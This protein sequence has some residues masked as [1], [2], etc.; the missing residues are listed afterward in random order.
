MKGDA[1]HEGRLGSRREFLQ[2][3]G[4][5]LAATGLTAAL[6]P[7]VY[8]GENNTIKVALVGCGGRGSGAAANALATSGP[9]KLWAVADVFENRIEAS[10]KYLSQQFNKQVD[11]SADRR[12]IGLDAY[13]KAIDSLD[14][15]DVVILATPPAFR[16]IHFEY[17]VDKGRNVF[18]EKSFAVDAPGVH[19]VMRA[20][21]QAAQKG[22]KVAAGL[23]WRHD[24]PRQE[25]IHRLH[26]GAIGEIHTLRTYRMHAA[27]GFTPK[28][29]GTSELAHQII[30][31][32][33]F[34]WL[35]GSFFVDWLIHNIDVCCW[36]KKAWPVA[37]QGQGGRQVRTEPDQMFDHYAVEYQFADGG[38]LF[39]Q[40][41]HMNGCWGTFS[42]YAH[43]SK[44]SAVIMEDLGDPKPRIYNSQKQVRE[45]EVWRYSGPTC[46]PYQVE[47][48][49]L[50]DAIR[51][52][53][54]YNETQRA[55]EAVM[56]A[57][58]GRMAAFS[59]QLITWEEAMASQREE[60]PGLDKL[61]WDSN[62]PVMPDEQGHY[63]VAMPG[64]TKVL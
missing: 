19:R 36:V 35:N 49:L 32:S 23:M 29:S 48:E 30:N 14:D 42:D 58:L 22:L 61:T 37:A 33:N 46:N 27:V 45:N 54:P 34:T 3:T 21:E 60:A 41:R 63:P 47:H 39:A 2:K 24:V 6:A 15:G 7:R 62:P 8:A 43:G 56:T 26:D 28:A 1:N 44:G 5:V 9:T 25:V 51:Q 18:M 40:G 38:R 13:R 31:Y 50:F 52:D 16:P 4:S 57:I 10:L 55:A 17:A 11:V 53:K 20:G 64:I 59:G 12:F